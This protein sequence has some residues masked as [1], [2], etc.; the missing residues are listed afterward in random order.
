MFH[1]LGD[2][3]DSNAGC[4]QHQDRLDTIRLLNNLDRKGVAF[5]E[6]G[7]L[8]AKGRRHLARD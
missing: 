6:L 2:H 5:G 4:D 3:G 7:K 8:I 1:W